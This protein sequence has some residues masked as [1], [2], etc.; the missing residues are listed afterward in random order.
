MGMA[1][2]RCGYV[3]EHGHVQETTA[4]TFRY[5]SL[6]IPETDDRRTATVDETVRVRTKRYRPN[7]DGGASFSLL[8]LFPSPNMG[9]VRLS[10]RV[11]RFQFPP[12][13]L[14]LLLLWLGGTG[15]SAMLPLPALPY[16]VE[17][18]SP[19]APCGA[20]TNA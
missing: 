5:P 7:A 15:V 8:S 13:E 12:A 2:M 16:E 9:A 6:Y 3:R 18:P 11:A 10:F 1:V 17:K 14:E 19:T 4:S 20:G